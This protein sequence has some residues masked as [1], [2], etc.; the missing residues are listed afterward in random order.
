MPRP[1]GVLSA[2]EV[3]VEA[4]GDDYSYLTTSVYSVWND[5][6]NIPYE[7]PRRYAQV[8]G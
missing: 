7:L 8:G 5:T 3:V 6:D 1:A 4:V 2:A